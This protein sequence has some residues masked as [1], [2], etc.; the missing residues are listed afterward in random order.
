MKT[1]FF[2]IQSRDLGEKSA[3]W[4]D[5]TTYEP[6]FGWNKKSVK[7]EMAEMPERDKY[8]HGHYIWEYRLITR[9]IVDTVIS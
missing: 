7:K 3:K 9:K 5:E 4:E 8:H 2:V 1:E 6:K